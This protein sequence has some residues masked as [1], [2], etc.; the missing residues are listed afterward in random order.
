MR[1][2][3]VG[4]G[5]REHAILWRLRHD[6]DAHTLFAFPGNGGTDRIAAPIPANIA[7]VPDLVERISTLAPDL[8]VVGPEAPLAAGLSDKLNA[9]GI[10]C[11]GPVAAAARLE[12]SKAFAKHLM[13]ECG[14]PTADF[15]VFSDFDSLR[16]YVQNRPYPPTGW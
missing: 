9:L 3:V 6:R 14:I 1:I 11:F 10:P 13:R 5:G 2:A 15:E 8:V 12:S 16:Q 7:N 4:S